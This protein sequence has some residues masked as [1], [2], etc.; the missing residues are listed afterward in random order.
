MFSPGIMEGEVDRGNKGLEGTN[1]TSP[2]EVDAPSHMD[3]GGPIGPRSVLFFKKY[4]SNL[5]RMCLP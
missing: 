2:A 5:A 3:P 4:F 1:N